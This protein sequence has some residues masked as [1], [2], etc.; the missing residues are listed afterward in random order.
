MLLVRIIIR[1]MLIL[2]QVRSSKSYFCLAWIGNGLEWGPAGLKPPA[3]A[4]K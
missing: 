4:K 3:G 1:L 2:S